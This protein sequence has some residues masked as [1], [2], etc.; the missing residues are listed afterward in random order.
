VQIY[1]KVSKDKSYYTERVSFKAG[2]GRGQE[3]PDTPTET[4]VV[5]FNEENDVQM[6]KEVRSHVLNT[7]R[8]AENFEGSPIQKQLDAI[9]ASY[10]SDSNEAD[11]EQEDDTPVETPEAP[12]APKPTR[13]A[14]KPAAAPPADDEGSPF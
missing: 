14:R 1:N 8:Q 11:D 12:T 3:A 2:L 10:G 6:L 9:K 5:Q 4:F 7:I 13:T